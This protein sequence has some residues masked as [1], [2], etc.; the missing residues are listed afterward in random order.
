MSIL[1]QTP[2]TAASKKLASAQ[3]ALLRVP[4]VLITGNNYL[5][6]PMHPDAVNFHINERLNGLS[7][8]KPA[9]KTDR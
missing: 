9:R 8:C 2:E 4:S 7:I 5:L 3:S 1:S 6:N